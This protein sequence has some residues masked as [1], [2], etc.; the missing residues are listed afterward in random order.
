M[1]TLSERLERIHQ[2]IQQSC[3]SVGRMAVALYDEKTDLLHTFLCSC[4][5]N[6]L[7][8]Y[9][10]TL[11]RVPSLQALAASGENRII[12]DIPDALSQSTAHHSQQIIQEGYRSSL[13]I[14]LKLQDK[15]IGFLFFDSFQN[16]GF[17]KQ[18]EGTFYFT[19]GNK[20][21][22]LK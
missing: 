16:N 22:F 2:Q 7:P 18:I 19:L 1:V 12:R 9:Q 11:S 15:L 20:K 4:R 3:E 13:T 21:I 5:H 14:P 10:I 17:S 8:N 6:P